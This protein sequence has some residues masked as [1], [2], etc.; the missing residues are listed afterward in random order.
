MALPQR[1]AASS[2]SAFRESCYFLKKDLKNKQQSQWFISRHS[3]R[4]HDS[5]FD[6]SGKVF[7]VLFDAVESEQPNGD[8]SLKK[9]CKSFLSSHPWYPPAERLQHWAQKPELSGSEAAV[10][11]LFSF[12]LQFLTPFFF[13]FFLLHTLLNYWIKDFSFSL[14][15]LSTNILVTTSKIDNH[16]Y[17]KVLAICEEKPFLRRRQT[18]LILKKTVI[19]RRSISR[20]SCCLLVPS[21]LFVSE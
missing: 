10:T 6:I 18:W 4:D 8:G 17:R 5:Y 2:V 3:C 13:Y 11:I 12:F 7:E 9:P 15:N 20:S 19:M 14:R 16:C 1:D 21:P